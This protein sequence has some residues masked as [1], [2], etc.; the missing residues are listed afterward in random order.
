MLQFKIEKVYCDIGN[1][2]NH[3]EDFLNV[4]LKWE[5]YLGGDLSSFLYKSYFWS[6]K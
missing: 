5:N 6:A 3:F 4:L 2:F 1:A